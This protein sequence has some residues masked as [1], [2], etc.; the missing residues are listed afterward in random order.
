MRSRIVVWGTNSKDEK[1][2]L[3][4]ALNADDN[5]I[6]I[7]SIPEKE[8]TEEF[9]NLMMSEWREGKDLEIPNT[10]E[11]RVNELTMADGILPD[12][13]RVERSDIIQRAQ[14]EWHF[15]VLS[16]KLYRNFKTEL[17][18]FSDRVKRMELFDQG[19]WDELKGLGEGVQK[20]IYDKNLFRDHSDSL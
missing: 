1:V 17:E 10:A 16:S 2:L 11:H 14:M 8:I 19:V 5:K 6:D 9:Y 15:V 18:D 3:A 20:H 4:I 12:D 13:I 7:W